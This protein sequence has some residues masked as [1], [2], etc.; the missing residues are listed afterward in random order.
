L[1]II[2]F[3]RIA[4]FGHVQH[5]VRPTLDT[6]WLYRR[7]LIGRGGALGFAGRLYAA[8]AI[9]KLGADPAT[10]SAPFVATLVDVTGLDH[11]LYRS[12]GVYEGVLLMFDT[13]TNLAIR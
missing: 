7:L 6:G 2:G 1:G 11:L 5:H 12:G 9:K 3:F 4:A 13:Y 8:A 10:S